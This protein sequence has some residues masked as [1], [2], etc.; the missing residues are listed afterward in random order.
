MKKLIIILIVLGLAIFGVKLF[1]ENKYESEIDEK[2][3]LAGFSGMVNYD[4]VKIGLDSSIT[5]NGIWVSPPNL[6]EDINIGFIQFKSSDPLMPIKG[7]EIFADGNFPERF[8][9]NVSDVDVDAAIM[10]QFNKESMGKKVGAECRSLHAILLPTAAGIERL[11]VDAFFELDFRDPTRSGVNLKM[12]DQLSS[13]TV[14]FE[15]DA[16]QMANI[17]FGGDI[18]ITKIEY[19]TEL[20]ANLMTEILDYCADK[21]KVTKEVYLNKVVS[22]AKFSQNSFGADL[23]SDMRKSLVDFVQGNKRYSFRARPSESM[24]SFQNIMGLRANQILSRLNLSVSLDGLRVPLVI[25]RETVEEKQKRADQISG[26]QKKRERQRKYEKVN[27]SSE[28][29]GQRIRI[30]RK[31]DKKRIKGRMSGLSNG[32]V[33]VEVYR[34][35]GEMTL[36]VGVDDILNFEVYR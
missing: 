34:Y 15:M 10:E 31:G 28:Y 24:G 9:I 1:L 32:R 30:S 7:P 33:S 21:F 3:T 2:L 6:D 20:D 12:L 13:S 18:P 16:T 8:S 35:G 5:I 23:G 29:I 36:T 17:A 4:N 26:N 14:E 22:S 11:N 25:A 27:L 19:T